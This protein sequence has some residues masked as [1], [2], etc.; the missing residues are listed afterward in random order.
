MDSSGACR[1]AASGTNGNSP[2]KSRFKQ[3]FFLILVALRQPNTFTILRPEV[4]KL[5]LSYRHQNRRP[6]EYCAE[7]RVIRIILYR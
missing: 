4:E 7:P 1:I 6:H 5:F 2:A 3:P